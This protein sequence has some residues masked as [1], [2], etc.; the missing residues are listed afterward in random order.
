M[1]TYTHTNTHITFVLG[2]L[3]ERKNEGKKR[4]VGIQGILN[5]KEVLEEFC[6]WTKNKHVIL[7]NKKKCVFLAGSNFY[8]KKDVMVPDYSS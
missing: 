1:H 8:F 3:E 6:C 4:R 7:K 2:M 5:S